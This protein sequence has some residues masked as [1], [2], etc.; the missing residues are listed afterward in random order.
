MKTVRRLA[1]MAVF[2]VLL[3]PVAAA[4]ELTITGLDRDDALYEDIRNGSLL[5]EQTGEGASATPHELLAAAQADYA[6]LLAILYDKG[7]FGP[8]INITLDGI[9]AANIPPVQPPNRISRVVV[10]VSPGPRFR[11]AKTSVA[12]LAPGTELPEGFAPG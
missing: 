11:F 4:A 10:R 1:A 7:Y 9:E 6:R 2:C 8:V 5:A 3:P 12:P